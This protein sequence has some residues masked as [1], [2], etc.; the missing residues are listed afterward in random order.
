MADYQIVSSESV[1]ESFDEVAAT[2]GGVFFNKAIL[3]AA[4]AGVEQLAIVQ[5]DGKCIGG[6]NLQVIKLKGFKTIASPQ[7]HPH[8]GLFLVPL[9]GG[10][11]TILSRTKKIFTAISDYLS[12]RSEPIISISFPPKVTD[13]QPFIWDGFRS[14]VRYTY[15]LNLKK[16]LNLMDVYSSKTRNSINKARK[17]GV[18]INLTPPNSEVIEMLTSN[19]KEQGFMYQQKALAELV[20]QASSGKGLIFSAILE[21]QTVATAVTIADD[22]VAYY[23]FGG[24]DRKRNVQGALGFVLHELM[25][26]H[27]KVERST[28]DF[29]GSMIPAVEN[30]FR[31]FGGEQVPYYMITKAP[32][33]LAPLL[34]LKGKKEF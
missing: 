1:Q 12:G 6:F 15:Q 31:G 18:T 11:S 23:L 17:S 21:E 13:M 32:F 3:N 24:V 2:Y 30:F 8:C 14:S 4:G 19:A 5:N 16:Q 27:Q 28:F 34:R 29:E 33:W 9:E 10:T 26:A 25:C 20:E 22:N 7:F